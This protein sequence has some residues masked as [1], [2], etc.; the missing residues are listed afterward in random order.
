LT[1]PQRSD[2]GKVA[3]QLVQRSRHFNSR[4]SLHQLKRIGLHRHR[5]RHREHALALD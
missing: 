3:P 4:V 5:H 2:D 1:A